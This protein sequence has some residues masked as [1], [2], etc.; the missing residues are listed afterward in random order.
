MI[1]KEQIIKILKSYSTYTDRSRTDECVHESNFDLIAKDVVK[2]L[3]IPVVVGQSEQ[4]NTA[5]KALE[6]VGFER[7]NEFDD[8]DINEMLG[9]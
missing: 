8:D 3:T 4:L 5:W 1:T 6:W 9:I 2:K 7:G